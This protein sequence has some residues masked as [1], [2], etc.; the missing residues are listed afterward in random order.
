MVIVLFWRKSWV[1]R[2]DYLQLF[3]RAIGMKNESM[4]QLVKVSNRSGADNRHFYD[5]RMTTNIVKDVNNLAESR[6]FPSTQ[7]SHAA[8][9][10][11]YVVPHTI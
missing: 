1:G 6:N 4:E 5:L 7:S 8:C 2:A 9:S 10:N 3:Y 11:V